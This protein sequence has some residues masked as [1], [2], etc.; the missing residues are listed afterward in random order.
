VRAGEGREVVLFIFVEANMCGLG[1]K[2][3]G[4]AGALRVA[5]GGSV[6][7]EISDVSV[8]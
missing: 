3:W 1:D 6:R 2:C 7:G 4:V 5:G 8:L